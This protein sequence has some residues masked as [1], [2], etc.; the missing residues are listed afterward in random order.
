MHPQ[1]VYAKT[2]KGVLEIKN[3][4][5][6]QYFESEELQ[7]TLYEDGLEF[8]TDYPV[9]DETIADIFKKPSSVIDLLVRAK[10]EEDL[11]A[12]VL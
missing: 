7:E 9:I 11:K 4:T 6:K 3:K 5:V 1:T 12:I 10:G 8:R 2:S